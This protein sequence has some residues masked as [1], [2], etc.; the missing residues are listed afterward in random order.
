MNILNENSKE[1][2]HPELD[3]LPSG[4]QDVLMYAKENEEALHNTESKILRNYSPPSA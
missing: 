1:I 3:S 2:N 4:L